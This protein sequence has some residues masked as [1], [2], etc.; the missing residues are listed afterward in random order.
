MALTET[1]QQLFH[2]FGATD[3]AIALLAAYLWLKGR[4]PLFLQ[5]T[6]VWLAL[7]PA[8][9]YPSVMPETTYWLGM[10]PV[11]FF[12]PY[13]LIAKLMAELASRPISG[14]SLIRA[15]LSASLLSNLAY[16]L[17]A[18]YLVY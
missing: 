10:A 3:V 16:L 11:T 8:A 15:A 12:P 14:R 9:L 18:P 4:N 17:G 6:F 2:F 13:Y 1:T 7:I 5:L